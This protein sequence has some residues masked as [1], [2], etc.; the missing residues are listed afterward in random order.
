[1]GKLNIIACF[2]PYNPIR[3]VTIQCNTKFC[4]INYSSVDCY[5]I[6]M[7][8]LIFY[9]KAKRIVPTTAANFATAV[10]IRKFCEILST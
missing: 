7:V 3:M 6:I 10:A 8:D 9:R 4:S 1:M 5:V 2:K